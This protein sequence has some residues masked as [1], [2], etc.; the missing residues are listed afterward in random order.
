[1]DCQAL[2]RYPFCTCIAIVIIHFWKTNR[3]SRKYKTYG[4]ENRNI[5]GTQWKKLHTNQ[6]T[7]VPL[8][9]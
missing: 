4:V 7:L 1:M 5:L 8:A 2:S 9:N 6:T 3:K